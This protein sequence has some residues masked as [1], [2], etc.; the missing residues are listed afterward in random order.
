[1]EIEPGMKH[2][3][4]LQFAGEAD[5]HPDMDSGDVIVVLQQKPHPTIKREGSDLL[6]E[7]KI[8]LT[9]A[10]TGFNFIFTH[11]DGR[12][13][14]VRSP[15]GRVLSQDCVRGLSGEGLPR[16]RSPGRGNL[17]FKFSVV[18]PDDKF[19]SD[20]SLKMIEEFLPKR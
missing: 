19:A 14:M 6:V 1:M 20:E 13:L 15:P 2:G 9:E 11:L 10:L 16:G 3:Q 5:Q 7:Q 17:Y 4:K 18:F 8:T 12:K